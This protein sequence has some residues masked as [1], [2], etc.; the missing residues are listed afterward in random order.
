MDCDR[1]VRNQLSSH[2]PAPMHVA[3]MTCTPSKTIPAASSSNAIAS[4]HIPAASFGGAEAART[5]SD[6]ARWPGNVSADSA[7][8]VTP[9]NS[10]DT[11]T[12]WPTLTTLTPRSSSPDTMLSTATL[13]AATASICPFAG[14]SGS[15]AQQRR[16]SVLVFPVPGGPCHSVR[17]RPRAASIALAWLALSGEAAAAAAAGGGDEDGAVVPLP[18]LLPLPLLPLRGWEDGGAAR[19]RADLTAAFSRS[20]GAVLPRSQ[21]GGAAAACSRVVPGRRGVWRLRLPSGFEGVTLLK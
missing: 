9:R 1:G 15:A 17:V 16:W 6:A 14:R 10:G 4:L 11:L 13:L 21:L 19:A 8:S 7:S 3:A 2:S 18:L 20:R 12:G 5:L